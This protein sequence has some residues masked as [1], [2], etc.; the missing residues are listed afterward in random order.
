VSAP[1]RILVVDDTAANV[2]LLEAVLGAEGYEVISASSGEEGLAAIAG[3]TPDVVLLDILMPGIDGYEVCRRLRE[4]P[5]TRGLPVLMITAG[6]E[7]QKVAALEAGADDFIPKPFDRAELLARVRSLLRIKRYQDTVRQQAAELTELNRTLEARV[8]EQVDQ[9]E[10]L[11]GLRRFLPRQLADLIVSAGEEAVLESHRAEI[12]LIHARLEGFPA[13]AERAEPE[14]VIDVLRGF[15]EGVGALIERAGAT[16]GSVTG[17]GLLVFLNDPIPCEE[18]AWRAVSLAVAMRDLVGRLSAGWRRRG[19]DLSFAAGVAT[20]YATLGRMGFEGRWEY[21]P[22]GPVVHLAGRLAAAAGAGQVVVSGPCH[23]Q[24][25][26]RVAAEPAGDIVA[27]GDRPPVPVMTVLAV[28]GGPGDDGE[29]TP[30]EVEVLRLLAEGLS[31]RAIAERLVISEKTA[32]RHVSNI[33]M[34]LD[35]HN[36]AEATRQALERGLVA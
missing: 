12:A 31:N 8:A 9:I 33:F 23:A 10:R 22:I 14:E 19:H 27:D 32:I 16:V 25:E 34:K 28:Q 3:G 17:T 29:L 20:G 2:R 21:G 4:E 15:H 6:G 24:I 5:T 30:R 18:P 1:G 11:G 26:S 35:V 36:R 7:Q 13:F